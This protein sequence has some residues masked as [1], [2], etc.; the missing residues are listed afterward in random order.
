[1]KAA[2]AV[3][4][5][6]EPEFRTAGLGVCKAATHKNNHRNSSH[7][8]LLKHNSVVNSLESKEL[9]HLPRLPF[10]RKL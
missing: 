3:A 5:L 7:R 2:G 6:A 9:T 1:M 10:F 4:Q 8:K